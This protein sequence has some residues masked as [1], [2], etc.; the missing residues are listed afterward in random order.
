MT[1]TYYV[2][3]TFVGGTGTVTGKYPF[4]VGGYSARITRLKVDKNKYAPGDTISITLDA[5]LNLAV[6]NGTVRY[7]IYDRKNNLVD[8]FQVATTLAAA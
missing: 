6:D 2:E 5:E 7:R 1:G 4:D 8:D 3:Y